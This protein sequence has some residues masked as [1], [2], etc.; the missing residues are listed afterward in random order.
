MQLA[1][2]EAHAGDSQARRHADGDPGED[3]AHFTAAGKR[4]KPAGVEQAVEPVE[5]REI[6]FR[7]H[8]QRTRWRPTASRAIGA[9]APEMW[10]KPGA[11][12]T[13]NWKLFLAGFIW[14]L[15]IDFGRRLA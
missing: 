4:T 7:E 10:R 11:K 14:V 12:F 15:A 3:H 2:K 9:L 5:A 13:T 8:M 6:Q 1:R